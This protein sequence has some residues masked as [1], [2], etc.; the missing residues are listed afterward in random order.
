MLAGLL[1]AQPARAQGAGSISG[2]LILIEDGAAL[3]DPDEFR[4]AVVYFEPGAGAFVEATAEPLIMTT[5]RR[6]FEPRVLV[7][8]A[9]T[10]VIFPNEDPIL[11]NVFSTSAN[12]AFDLGL[13]GRSEGKI[14]RFDQPGLVRVFCNVHPA[15][16][17]H[18]VVLDTPHFVVPD[19]DGRFTL[20]GLP[21]GPGRLTLWHERAEPMQLE[22]TIA[23]RRIDIGITELQLTVR[24][25]GQQ[26]ERVRRPVRRGRY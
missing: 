4:Q 15:M 22:Q 8:T 13:Y 18:I 24:Q 5:R 10:E 26:R 16:S 23:D 2:Q 9:G 12:N 19:G 11:H 25:L 7:V 6:Q 3:K 1:V 20:S 14:H 21:P 17:A